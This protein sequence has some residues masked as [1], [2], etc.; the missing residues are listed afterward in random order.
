MA[1]QLPDLPYSKDALAPHISA[2]TLEFHWG[3]HHRAYF[4]KTNELV[5]GKQDLSGASLVDVVR[6]AQQAGDNKLFNNSA[7]AWNHSFFWQCLSPERQQPSGRLAE[8][9]NDSFGGTDQ[10]LQK[11]GD[12]AV[13]HFSNGWAWLVLDRDQLKITSLHDADTPLVHEGMVPLFTLDVWEHAYYI[14]YRNERPRFVSSV[15]S[16][17]VNWDFVAQNLDGRGEQRANQ[18]ED[19]RTEELTA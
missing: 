13:N 14:D 5:E 4:N 11:L 15:L 18:G 19:A 3:K 17:A 6:H 9:I 2:E 8:L 16:N 7:Q 12:E 1:F 10:L